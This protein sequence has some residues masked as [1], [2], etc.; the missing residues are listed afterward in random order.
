MIEVR[1]ETHPAK[2]LLALAHSGDYMQIGA[3]FEGLLATAGSLGLLGPDSTVIGIYHDNPDTTPTDRLRSHACVTVPPD[4][5]QIPDGFEILN[6]SAG[7]VAVGVHRGPYSGL[8][9]S[10]G[11]LYGEWLPSSGRSLAER[12]SYEIYVDDPGTTK[13]EELRTLI[14]LPLNVPPA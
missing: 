2:R 8:P 13:P 5:E 7:E 11:W 9:Q 3:K 6:L 4:F 12:P 1:L 14:C 10:Y